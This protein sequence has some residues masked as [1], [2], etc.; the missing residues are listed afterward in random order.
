[1]DKRAGATQTA[2]AGRGAYKVQDVPRPWL[3]GFR[4]FGGRI[5]DCADLIDREAQTAITETIRHAERETGTEMMV[6]TL[7]SIGGE[8]PKHF[9]TEL[10]NA[11]RIGRRAPNNGVLVLLVEDARRIEVEVGDGAVTKLSRSWTDQMIEADVLPHFKRSRNL[12]GAERR[13]E[14]SLGLERC[15]SR[16]ATRLASESTFI[17][18]YGGLVLYGLYMGG[19]MT[20][21]IPAGS[22][23]SGGSSGGSGYSSGG[24]GGGG[25][26]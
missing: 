16:C 23:G 20:G 13:R 18:D 1:V 14:Y 12:E 19:V 11:W 6:V 26:W 10:F 3:V 24:G 17:E 4:E 7:P 8:N 15:V 25:S 2:A 22:G 9:A 21:V 5:S